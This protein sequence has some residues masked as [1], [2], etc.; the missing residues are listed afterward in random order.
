MEKHPQTAQDSNT[1]TNTSDSN[2]SVLFPTLVNQLYQ[3]AAKPEYLRSAFRAS[4]IYPLTAKAIPNW[5]LAPSLPKTES[6]TEKASEDVTNES[7]EPSTQRSTIDQSEDH[8]TI[9]NMS[10][11]IVHKGKK[12]S[13]EDMKSTPNVKSYFREYFTKLLRKSPARPR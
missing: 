6:T 4:G 8:T 11:K 5:K 9:I 7:S 3:E 10:V 2:T 12:I 1:N 13:L